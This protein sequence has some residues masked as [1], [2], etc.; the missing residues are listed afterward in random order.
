MRI[1]GISARPDGAAA[2][3]LV[4]EGQVVAAVEQ[5]RLSE[6]NVE[7]PPVFGVPECAL[8]ACLSIGDIAADDVDVV[9]VAEKPMA[10]LSRTFAHFQRRGPRG[11]GD[12]ARDMGPILRRQL[13]TGR[14]VEV[15]MRRLGREQP[16]T[17]HYVEQQV[18]HAA[19]AFFTSGF[20][21]AATLVVDQASEWATSSIGH[22]SGRR[23]DLL[24]EQ[25]FPD[26]LALVVEL[27][28]MWCGLRDHGDMGALVD[29][30][31]DGS[32]SFA[33][34]LTRLVQVF[35]DGSVNVDA[36]AVRWWAHRPERSRHLRDLFGG[37][38]CGPADTQRAA[39]LARSVQ[40]LLEMSLSRMATHALGATGEGR[41]CVGGSL[42]GNGAAIRAAMAA[43]GA[44]DLWVLPGSGNAAT[45]IG[46]A[47][48]A[49]HSTAPSPSV[50]PQH[51]CDLPAPRFSSALGPR[52]ETSEIQ[53]MLQADGVPHRRINKT[54]ELIIEVAAA[55]ASGARVGWFEGR[56]DFGA[57]S[58][59]HRSI[60][61]DPR[62]VESANDVPDNER[63]R[64]STPLAVLSAHAE[65]W[66]RPV[67]TSPY[68]TID[69]APAG[70]VAHDALHGCTRSDG[71]TAVHVVERSEEPLFHRLLE[72]FLALTG[73]PVMV[74][75]PLRSPSGV[76]VGTPDAALA[77]ARRLALDLLVLDDVV[78]KVG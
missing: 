34:Q 7:G 76:P 59:A 29:L 5:R 24:V 11:L 18:S 49:W 74:A 47:L 35:E 69:A 41:I 62:V 14:Q 26:S 64:T 55:L 38:P 63:I 71:T 52:F 4:V 53:G 42:A 39:N 46:A 77:S 17:T 28:G 30:A 8:A 66:F 75:V 68:A 21:S 51:L 1:L 67:P 45:A 54:E 22:A 33:D 78:V 12:F 72:A 9:A 73:C 43:S 13:F 57:R 31:A 2:A 70:A 27:V 16:V 20:T 32:N 61:M 23:I 10:V 3:A 56:T 60:L 37:P 48:W 15:S 65:N 58:P 6:H 36:S 50:R 19:A 44:T 25:R 40:E